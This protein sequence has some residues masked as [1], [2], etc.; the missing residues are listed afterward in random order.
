MNRMNVFWPHRSGRLSALVAL[1]GLG[2]LFTASGAKGRWL[3][4]SI[5]NRRRS[6]NSLC[7]SSRG[8]PSR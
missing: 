4:A 6:L 2:L 7:D 1:A 5:Q 8:R 3:R